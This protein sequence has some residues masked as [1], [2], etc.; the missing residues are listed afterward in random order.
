MSSERMRQIGYACL[1]VGFMWGS[2]I[3]VAQIK[4]VAWGPYSVAFAITL[5]G[6]VLA[7]LGNRVTEEHAEQLGKD[8]SIIDAALDSLVETV[9]DLNTQREQSDVF[10]MCGRIDERCMEDINNFVEAREAITQR[11][12]LTKYAEVMDSFAL[13]ERALNRAW[14]ASADGYIDELH[15]C[16]ERAEVRLR[17]ARDIVKDCI[18]SA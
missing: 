7:R 18:N 10:A 16:L 15:I 17:A 4:A 13:G 3:T 8:I 5:V 9:S 14:C 6:V 11:Y 12:G 1:A 2:Y